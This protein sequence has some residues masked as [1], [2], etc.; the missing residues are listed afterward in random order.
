MKKL[1]KIYNFI[2]KFFAYLGL[3][4]IYIIGFLIL[5]TAQVLTC[6]GY[7]FLFEPKSA[8][9]QVKKIFSQSV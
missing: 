3:I 6:I 7:L 1:K 4:P 5:K 2:L 8:D 9:S